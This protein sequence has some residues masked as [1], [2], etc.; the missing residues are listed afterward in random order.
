MQK[1]F[2]GHTGVIQ[3]NGIES[4]TKLEARPE[5]IVVGNDEGTAEVARRRGLRHLPNVAASDHGTPLLSD[6]FRQAEA[7]ATS[8]Y[9]CYVNADIILLNDFLRAV[10]TAQKKYPKSLL[11]S[12]RINFDIAEPLNFGAGWEEAIK[13]RASANGND[14]HY[15]RIEVFVFP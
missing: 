3:R 2:R 1:E 13:Q 6:L 7:A 11:V 8:P 12:K 9:L 5:I 15:S 4:W 10:E 14:E